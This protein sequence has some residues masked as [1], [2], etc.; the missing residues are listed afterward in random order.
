M[1]RCASSH[2]TITAA[3]AAWRRV[4]LDTG[5]ASRPPSRPPTTSDAVVRRVV[6]GDTIIARIEGDDER[7]RMLGV[8]APESVRPNRPVECFG[9]QASARARRCCP[10]ARAS[11]SRATRLRVARDQYGRL[12]AEVTLA[13]AGRTVNEQLIAEGYAEVFRGDGRGAPAAAPASGRVRGR[14]RRP[15]AASGAPAAEAAEVDSGLSRRWWLC[16]GTAPVVGAGPNRL[17]RVLPARQP[18]SDVYPD[19]CRPAG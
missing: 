14:A 13:G 3:V 9:P 1:R 19:A 2:V 4:R 16:A 11:C 8:D 7:V 12:L 15:A 6:D 18:H 5:S 10:R 17:G